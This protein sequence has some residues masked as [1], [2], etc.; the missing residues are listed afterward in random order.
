M[1]AISGE[2]VFANMYVGDDPDTHGHPDV[3]R[4]AAI[5]ARH[6]RAIRANGID[7]PHVMAD[8]V[9]KSLSQETKT[10]YERRAADY[11]GGAPP[12]GPA[13]P[14]VPRPLRDSSD[15]EQDVVAAAR[16]V[17]AQRR[18][19]RAQELRE[20]REER[21]E[22]RRRE[23]A[24]QAQAQDAKK[25][26]VAPGA[27]PPSRRLALPI[28]H[29]VTPEAAR[30][31]VNKLLGAR[32]YSRIPDGEKH[33][34]VATYLVA[35]GAFDAYAASPV[36]PLRLARGLTD[37]PKALALMVLNPHEVVRARFKVGVYEK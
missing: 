13:P 25:I 16:P 7:R 24:E 18:A 1:D 29:D 8:L 9:W 36:G 37:D 35:S 22:E 17:A 33:Q 19:Q 15:D 26:V 3:V 31:E 32:H 2:E 5:A 14:P 20:R 23:L 30:E 28:G 27:V 21:R 4:A 11:A 10:L 34:T 12:G 6:Q